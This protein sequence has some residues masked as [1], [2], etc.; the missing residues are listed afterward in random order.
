MGTGRPNPTSCVGWAFYK[1]FPSKDDY[2]RVDEANSTVPCWQQMRT[3]DCE[4][5]K[6]CLCACGDGGGDGNGG[7]GNESVRVLRMRGWGGR[8]ERRVEVPS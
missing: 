4:Y 5:V 6:S 3:E 1:C 8:R 7:R 2:E